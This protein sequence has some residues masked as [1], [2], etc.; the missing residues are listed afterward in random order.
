M[1]AVA[2]SKGEVVQQ[3]EEEMEEDKSTWKLVIIDPEVDTTST[4]KLCFRTA[5]GEEGV[6]LGP[7]YKYGYCLAHHYCL[8]FSSGLNQEGEDEE[9]VKGFLPDSI[10]KEWRRGSMLKC[11][12]CKKKYAT[13]GCAHSNCKKGYHLPCGLENDSLQQFYGNFASFCSSHRPVQAPLAKSGA[14]TLNLKEAECGVCL[15]TLEEVV[16]NN[17]LWAPCCGGWAHRLVARLSRIQPKPW[18][19]NFQ[20]SNLP[21]F[22]P[23]STFPLFASSFRPSFLNYLNPPFPQLPPGRAWSGW[24]LPPAPI[25]SS[26]PSVTTGMNSLRR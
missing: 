13:V 17:V 4:C 2:G 16:G 6:R 9:G 15:D 1:A 12:Y 23:R 14:A 25:T 20:S 8:M 5:Q 26:A 7:L 18:V 19:P 22:Q 3:E 21:I 11:C 24:P 10:V